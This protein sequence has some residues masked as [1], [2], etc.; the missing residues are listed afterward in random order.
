MKYL[1]KFGRVLIER[2]VKDKTN[3]GII[4]PNAQ[5]HAACEGVIVA[6]GETAGWVETIESGER[7]NKQ[8]FSVGD[9]V[10]FGR[11]AGTWL[12][13]TYTQSGANDDGKLFMCADADILA[14]IKED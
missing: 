14:V 1:P 12:D 3:G 8:I 10:I 5:K 6:L 11:H 4:L 13:A 9:K 7:V 2:D